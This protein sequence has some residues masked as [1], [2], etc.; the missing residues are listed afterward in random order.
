MKMKD[1]LKLTPDEIR[2]KVIALSQQ[3]LD[4]RMKK[5]LGQLKTP[6]EIRMLHKDIARLKTV[7]SQ[8]DTSLVIGGK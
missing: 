4:L 3:Y 7:L 8:H 6:S 5:Q 1:I 2:E